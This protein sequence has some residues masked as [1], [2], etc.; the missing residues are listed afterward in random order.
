[1]KIKD[2]KY[3]EQHGGQNYQISQ[4]PLP[5]GTGFPA[6]NNYNLDDYLPIC[7]DEEWSP[8]CNQ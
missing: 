6:P 3:V 5:Q 4:L 2:V 1:M 8:I 7:D